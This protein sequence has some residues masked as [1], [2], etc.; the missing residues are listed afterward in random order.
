MPKGPEA[1]MVLHEA[2]NKA[3]AMFFEIE[4]L[5]TAEGEAPANGSLA[6]LQVLLMK[7]VMLLRKARDMLQT[8]P[9]S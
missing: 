2:I 9:Q 8:L 6:N 1:D 7:Q 4:Y 3:Q 5:S